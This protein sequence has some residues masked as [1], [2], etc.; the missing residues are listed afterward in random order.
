MSAFFLAFHQ[1]A[2]L[3]DRVI[4]LVLVQSATLL[5]RSALAALVLYRVYVYR[6]AVD[7]RG[8]KYNVQYTTQDHVVRYSSGM[9]L[10]ANI[11]GRHAIQ[12]VNG[13]SLLV[14]EVLRIVTYTTMNI[15]LS[16]AIQLHV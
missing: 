12:I 14:W 6:H 1:I 15:E 11:I 16:T 2:D 5:D 9:Q 4:S 10:T 7:I 13:L 3:L 8:Y